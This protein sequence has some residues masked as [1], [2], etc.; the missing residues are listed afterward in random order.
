MKEDIKLFS[1]FWEMKSEV[2]DIPTYTGILISK[3]TLFHYLKIARI[4]NAASQF[5]QCQDKSG[6][7]QSAIQKVNRRPMLVWSDLQKHADP[8]RCLRF[9][10]W[11]SHSLMCHHFMNLAWVHPPCSRATTTLVP[12]F[13]ICKLPC[14]MNANRSSVPVLKVSLLNGF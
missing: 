10:F 1:S 12:A 4:L 3:H 13:I 7:F 6:C 5:L 9:P 8:K 11:T 14:F 2:F